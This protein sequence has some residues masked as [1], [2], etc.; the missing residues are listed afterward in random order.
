MLVEATAYSARNAA[1]AV[2]VVFGVHAAAHRNELGGVKGKGRDRFLSPT[3]NPA[4]VG[5]LVSTSSTDATDDFGR[6]NRR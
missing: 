6:L 4:G 2:V 1:T 5:L 3:F